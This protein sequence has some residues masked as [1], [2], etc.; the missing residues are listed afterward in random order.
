MVTD[1]GCDL[2]TAAKGL[3]GGFPCGAVIMTQEIA[4]GLKPGDLGTTFGGGP[5]A[6]AVIEAVIDTIDSEN[7][8]ENVRTMSALVRERC[9]TGPVESIRGAGLLLGLKTRARAAAVR[10]ALLAKNILVGTSADPNV[11]RLLPPLILQAQHVT[12]LAQA[13]EELNDAT[14]Q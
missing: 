12:R 7:L 5:L 11:L 4:K 10:D 1:Q 14:F 3:G 2:L 13:L 6:C 9:A 8:L